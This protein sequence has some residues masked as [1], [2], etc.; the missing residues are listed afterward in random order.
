MK[1]M[2]VSPKYI[3]EITNKGN[4]LPC[5]FRGTHEITRNCMFATEQERQLADQIAGYCKNQNDWR[6]KF[7]ATARILDIESVWAVE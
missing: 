5:K 1:Q 2:P 7:I 6:W 4:E 3:T